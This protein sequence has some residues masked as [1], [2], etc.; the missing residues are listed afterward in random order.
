MHKPMR[1]H[2]IWATCGVFAVVAI[3]TTATREVHASPPDAGA[4][5]ADAGAGEALPATVSAVAAACADRRAPFECFQ[6]A[7]QTSAS[8]C[9]EQCI[10]KIDDAENK[11]LEQVQAACEE[12]VIADKATKP[13]A[14]GF[15]RPGPREDEK[16]VLAALARALK[17]RSSDTN[18]VAARAF[19][20]DTA[21]REASCTEDCNSRG[22]SRVRAP[23]EGPGL[24]RQYK[25]CMVNADS[26]MEARKFALYERD[27]YDELIAAADKRCREAS[28]CRW[29]ETFSSLTCTY[30]PL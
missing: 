26:T 7:N 9:F 5:Q 24:V 29:V 1:L 8:A 28:K 30:N 25:V 2:L 17:T 21:K 15:G 23:I 12:R 20:L 3:A 10:G 6:F 27:L 4:A 16:T 19:A 18:A 11:R 13:M 22:K 14:C